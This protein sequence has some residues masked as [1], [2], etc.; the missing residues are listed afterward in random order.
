[1]RQISEFS[2]RLPADRI[3]IG[4]VYQPIRLC[5]VG[6]RNEVVVI[7]L[8]TLHNVVEQLV[9]LLFADV[10]RLLDR[11]S[12]LFEINAVRPQRPDIL[13]RDFVQLI[14]NFK[15]GTDFI[16]QRIFQRTE[17]LC[18]LFRDGV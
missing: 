14:G 1:M 18:K 13:Y 6:Q 7:A 10:C 5:H 2:E 3:D 15:P 17:Q 11:L 9:Q 16:Q 12:D 4:S 8:V